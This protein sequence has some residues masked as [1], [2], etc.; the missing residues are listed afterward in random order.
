LD[1]EEYGEFL[2]QR[3]LIVEEELKDLQAKKEARMLRTA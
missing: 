3:K 2:K 1:A